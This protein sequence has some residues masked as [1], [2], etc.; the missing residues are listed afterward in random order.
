MRQRLEPERYMRLMAPNAVLSADD[1][2]YRDAV[3]RP[4][5]TERLEAYARAAERAQDPERPAPPRRFWDRV[6]GRSQTA[7]DR[8]MAQLT[9]RIP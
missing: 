8:F 4:F 7:N 9:Q 5:F 3:M 2:R 6:I 1:A